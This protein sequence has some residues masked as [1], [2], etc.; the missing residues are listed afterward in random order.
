ML[1]T[2][3]REALARQRGAALQGGWGEGWSRASFWHEP[4]SQKREAQ[5]LQPCLGS[6]QL[7]FR[8]VTRHVPSPSCFKPLIHMISSLFWVKALLTHPQG[9]GYRHAR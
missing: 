8:R 2:P 3:P 5:A 9:A 6:A 7:L 1:P 4:E